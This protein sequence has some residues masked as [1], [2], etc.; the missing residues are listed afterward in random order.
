LISATGVTFNNSN[1]NVTVANSVINGAVTLQF[2]RVIGNVI[3]A[4]N[5]VGSITINTDASVSNPTDT[6]MI[7]GNKIQQFSSGSGA[8]GVYWNSTSQYFNISNN[9]ITLTYGSN[10]VNIGVY[11]L[12]S[13]TGTGT[14]IID[15][16]T[17]QKVSSTYVAYGIY[18]VGNATS[19]TEIQNNLILALTYSGTITTSSGNQSVHYNLGTIGTS[20]YWT[21]FTNDGTN[22]A[23]LNTTIDANGKITNL[24]SNAINGGTPDSAYVDINLTRNDCGAYGG[25]FTLDNFFPQSSN[26]WSRV[27]FVQAPRR[28]MVNG[29][30][31][32]RADGYDK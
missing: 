3:T 29:T 23:L 30:I 27:F 19:N 26:D 6:L 14:N 24:A 17:I 32:V 9:F 21:G 1:Y 12:A 4:S 15:N 28:V 2:G 18:S 5:N 11:V 31:N 22:A 10:Y 8:S 25:S 7:I 16:N 20:G 13:K